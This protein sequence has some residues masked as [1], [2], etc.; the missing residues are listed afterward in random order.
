MYCTD[1]LEDT[2]MEECT[3]RTTFT[4]AH[5]HP[6]KE[7]IFRDVDSQM[8][9]FKY[10]TEEGCAGTSEV[11]FGCDECD[12]VI[13]EDCTQKPPSSTSVKSTKHIHPLFLHGGKEKNCGECGSRKN[14]KVTEKL[15]VFRPVYVCELCKNSYCIECLGFYRPIKNDDDSDSESSGPGVDILRRLLSR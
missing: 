8:C 2:K 11:F 5:N 15:K 7:K 6:L 1:C 3:R 10:S 9:L 14:I 13:C 12:M 4:I